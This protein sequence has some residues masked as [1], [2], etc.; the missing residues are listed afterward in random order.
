MDPERNYSHFLLTRFNVKFSATSKA[1]S[2]DWLR[3][4]L[5]YFRQWALPSIRAQSARFDHWLIFCD[6]ASPA[7]FKDEMNALKDCN[8]TVIWVD[9]AMSSQVGEAVEERATRDYIITTR[10]DNDDAIAKDFLELVQRHFASQEFAFINLSNGVQYHDGRFYSYADPSN[11]FISLVERRG[12]RRARTVFLDW[13]T[14]LETHGPIERVRS[15]PAWIQ[16]VHGE[17][18]TNKIYG[19]PIRA[20]RVLPYFAVEVPVRQDGALAFAWARLRSLM[21]VLGRVIAKPA[22]IAKLFK[23]LRP[24]APKP[25]GDGPGAPG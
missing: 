8:I 5:G 10:L 12:Q 23:A 17:N 15:H 21:A 11:P 7:W 3:N 13:H 18:L 14:R 2:D 1:P 22:R 4:R 9:G 20:Q 16:N 24:S 19:M 25:A 6:G